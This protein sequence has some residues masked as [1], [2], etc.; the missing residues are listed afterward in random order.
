MSTAWLNGR[1]KIVEVR[2]SNLNATKRGSVVANN[3]KVVA[4]PSAL[5]SVASAGVVGQKVRLRVSQ[6]TGSTLTLATAV[7]RGMTLVKRGVA[8]PAGCEAYD[9]SAAARP[10]TIIGWTKAGN[11]R[12][13]TVPGTNLSGTSRTGGMGLANIAAVAKKMGLRFAFELDGGASVTW[14]T[15]SNAGTWTRRDLVGV[16]GGTYER[17]VDNGLAFLAPPAATP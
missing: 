3:T 11:W 7:G 8:A 14:Y 16:S 6:N 15:R 5:E 13:M 12:S 1:N 17:P 10:R 2:T 9:H 4:F